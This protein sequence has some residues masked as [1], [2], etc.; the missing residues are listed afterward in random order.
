MISIYALINPTKNSVFY[1]GASFNPVNRLYQHILESKKGT[2]KKHLEIRSITNSGE[3]VEMEILDECE[4]KD[5]SF[6]EKF[7]I[8]LF[9]SYGFD[10]HQNKNYSTYS[11]AQFNRTFDS[12]ELRPIFIHKS[13]YNAV[14]ILQEYSYKSKR[15]IIEESIMIMGK[16]LVYSNCFS[17]PNLDALLSEIKEFHAK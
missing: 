10:L 6:W 1:I 8:D 4:I 15:E 13:F 9:A 16:R 5:A 2:S 7:Y 12:S 3:N 17:H 11:K 14:K